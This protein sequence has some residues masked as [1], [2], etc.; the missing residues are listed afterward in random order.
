M[1]QPMTYD[2][3]LQ[4][5]TA[6]GNQKWIRTKGTSVFNNNKCVRL[7][8]IIQDI[9]EQKTKDLELERSEER[10]RQ[11][12]NYAKIGMALM[13]KNGKWIKVNK[14]LCDIV[15][16]SE[17]ELLK[18]TFQ[19]ITHPGDL[20][21]DL[22]LLQD[23]VDGKTETSQL[24]KRYIHKNGNYIWILLSVSAVKDENNKPIHFVTQVIDIT[25]RKQAEQK[26][27]E[28]RK[29][30]QTLI[31]NIPVNIFIKDNKSRKILVN[32]KEIEYLGAKSKEDILGKND[33]ELY[34]EASAKV[35]MEEDDSVLTSGK[36]II[37]KETF[38]TKKD[39]AS[40]WFLT[41]KIP[42]KN[43]ENKI[44]GL[45]GISYDIT[46]RKKTEQKL[47]DLLNVTTEQNTRLL[48]FAYIVSHNLR[49]HAGNFAML[50]EMID[51]EK[52]PKEKQK[53]Q[54]LLK[55]ASGNLTETINNLNEVV[56]V[57][58]NANKE[59]QKINLYEA[60]EKVQGNMKG[61][62]L[63]ENIAYINEVDKTYFVHVVPAYIDSILLNFL[64]NGIKYRSPDKSSYIKFST[65]KEN[66]YI[67]LSVEDNGLG[68]DLK[69]FG[70]SLFGMYKTFHGNKD[71]RG[72][73]LFITK[74]QIEAMGGKIDV[75]SVPKEGTTFKIYFPEK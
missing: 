48:N 13:A 22:T 56:A 63:K 18:L 73:G 7:F 14:S 69:R 10:F 16:Y 37:D 1:T 35:S 12:F 21:N 74:S 52:D 31:D 66:N 70:G 43:F 60:I 59:V 29:L 46:E 62:L 28:D 20:M 71:A 2:L 68:I 32:N 57:S 8:G 55:V 33:S 24:E 34:P 19:D 54:D 42:L 15:G 26:I 9:H 67:I 27:I 61:K 47:K 39:G 6:K 65:A 44:T 58:T 49:S 75:V 72:V 50:L 45:L 17:E 30:L 41:S 25:R 5:I 4:I 11:T 38:N 51:I 40:H 64:T 36:S 3:E 23:L 53:M